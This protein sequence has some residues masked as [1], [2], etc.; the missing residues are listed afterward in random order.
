MTSPS[1]VLEGVIPHE[2]PEVGTQLQQT[3]NNGLKPTKLD[4][5]LARSTRKKRVQRMPAGISDHVIYVY[6]ARNRQRW[7]I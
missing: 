1:T 4:G 7:R 2:I 3:L 5:A 6:G